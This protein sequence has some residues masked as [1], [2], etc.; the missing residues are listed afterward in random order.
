MCVCVCVIFTFVYDLPQ[1]LQAPRLRFAAAGGGRRRRPVGHT[2]CNLVVRVCVRAPRTAPHAAA[3]AAKIVFSP[4]LFVLGSSLSYFFKSLHVLQ[5]TRKNRHGFSTTTTTTC[6]T[7][8]LEFQNVWES[9]KKKKQ[10]CVSEKLM[11]DV[12]V[13]Y[14]CKLVSNTDNVAV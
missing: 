12:V 9:G 8:S 13:R 2:V 3:T 14:R 1:H 5:A 6:R 11:T 7:V 10:T 4:P